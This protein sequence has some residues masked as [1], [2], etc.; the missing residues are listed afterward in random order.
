MR[1]RALHAAVVLVAG[2]LGA[3]NAS[4]SPLLDT[5]GP[6]GGNA[7]VQGVVS[8]PGAA[9]TY[10]NPA[11]LSA[12][13]DGFL[14]S[15][16]FVSEQLGVTLDGRPAGS[17]VPLAVGARDVVG[18]DGSA[19]PNDRVPTAWLES[20][21]QGGTEPGNC[22]APGLAARARQ[23]NGASSKTRTYLT[24]G[25]VKH[26]VSGR[27]AIGV[28]SMLPVSSFVSARSFY[29]DEHE[30]LFSN[31]LQPELYGDRLTSLSFAF[32]GAFRI[33]PTFSVGL[34]A[35]LALASF[36]TASTYVRDAS[37]YDLLL[38]DTETRT[39]V[40]VAPILG[41]RWAPSD[42]LRF[43]G[44]IHA[45]QSFELETTVSAK[46]PAGS[47]SGT[48]RR[49]VYH[50]M[51]WRVAVGAEGDVVRRGA[52]TMAVTGSLKYGFWSSYVDRHGESPSTYGEDLAWKDTM[53]GALGVRHSYGPARAFIDLSFTPSPVPEQKGRSSYV[54]NDRAGLALGA[55]VKIPLGSSFVR[56]GFQ[57]SAQRLI[58]RHNTKDASRLV[59]ELPDGAVFDSTRDPVP[60]SAGLQT[61]SP[62]YPGFA[63]GGYLWSG[64]FS[65]EI[66]L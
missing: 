11:E 24:L 65:L 34:S 31:S 32:G 47:D 4:A 26:V 64:F 42:R 13:E 30:A 59:D 17:D 45:P 25:F 9:S 62:G 33:L 38:L 49:D 27:L 10:F 37:N 28:Y 21:C 16:G 51:P 53:T 61:N 39:Q 57:V 44:T 23:A 7:G 52:Y 41:A 60:G 6:V 54:D 15:F 3:A 63:S 58:P 12:A 66:P 48:T 8:G 56:P 19:L 36:A 18:R 2:T 29:A 1:R 14:A 35:T 20:G 5:T 43:G 46:L 22:P 40:N 55:D 50:W